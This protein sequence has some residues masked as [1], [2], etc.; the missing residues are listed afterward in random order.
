VDILDGD[1][2]PD[3]KLQEEL[4][5]NA[6]SNLGQDVS[7]VARMGDKAGDADRTGRAEVA[8][9]DLGGKVRDDNRSGLVRSCMDGVA[10]NKG[11][12]NT[13]S[14]TSTGS[15]GV[16]QIRRRFDHRTRLH[17]ICVSVSSSVL[18]LSGR[19]GGERQQPRRYG[20]EVKV[21]IHMDD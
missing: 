3:D 5:D 7:L 1:L 14:E 21:E 15:A 18:L 19:S 17:W 6:D 11:Q 20:A 9:D 10:D 8:Y 13:D 16:S 2:A 12:N 4:I